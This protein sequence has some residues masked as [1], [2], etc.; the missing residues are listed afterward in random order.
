MRTASLLV[1]A[2][3]FGQRLDA[4]HCSRSRCLI[5]EKLP[6]LF[7]LLFWQSKMP[8]KSQVEGISNLF[9]ALGIVSCLFLATL[10]QWL[11]SIWP[12]IGMDP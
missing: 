2:G 5:W 10:L 3:N 1:V 12:A 6:S 7:G 9:T 4:S 11:N 8:R